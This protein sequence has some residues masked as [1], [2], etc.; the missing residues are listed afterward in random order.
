MIFFGQDRMAFFGQD[1]RK[2]RE[3]IAA[4]QLAGRRATIHDSN[5]VHCGR[6]FMTDGTGTARIYCSDACWQAAYRERKKAQI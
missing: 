5:C 1:T 2:N 6:P 4:A 3:E